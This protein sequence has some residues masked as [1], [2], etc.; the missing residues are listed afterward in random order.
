MAPP[1]AAD[2]IKAMMKNPWAADL[3]DKDIE[4]LKMEKRKLEEEE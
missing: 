2:K 4:L 3:I 1:L